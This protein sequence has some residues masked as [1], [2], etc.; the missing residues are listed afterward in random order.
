MVYSAAYYH[1][2][3]YIKDAWLKQSHYAI[4]GII[5]SLI[6]LYFPKKTLY[7][8]SIL[9]TYSVYCPTAVLLWEPE[10]MH[11]AGSVLDQF[12][13]NHQNSQNKY[14]TCISTLFN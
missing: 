11:N 8:L 10:M 9:Y 13:F 7:N 4:G 1:Q 14:A 6:I 5:V 12:K 2:S 3:I